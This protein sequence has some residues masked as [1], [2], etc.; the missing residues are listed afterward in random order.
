MKS[1]LLTEKYLN[2]DKLEIDAFPWE[3]TVKE[4]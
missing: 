1:I 2:L 4:Q 3:H